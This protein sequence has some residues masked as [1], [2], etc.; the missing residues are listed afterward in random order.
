MTG[1]RVPKLDHIMRPEDYRI[2]SWINAC[3]LG[4]ALLLC[5]I[6][7]LQQM[8]QSTEIAYASGTVY[9][10]QQDRDVAVH[11]DIPT[12]AER[13]QWVST[14]FNAKQTPGSQLDKI[15]N[16]QRTNVIRDILVYLRSKTGEDLGENPEP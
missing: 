16:L 10:L 1:L 4:G 14:G 6:L 3:A 15:C 8:R 7:F 9:A 13:L 2:W 11:A 5:A 12:A